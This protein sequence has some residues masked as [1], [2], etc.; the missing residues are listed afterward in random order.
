MTLATDLLSKITESMT[1]KFEDAYVTVN[2]KTK[3]RVGHGR[4][5]STEAR[6]L[7]YLEGQN[8]HK[9]RN[10]KVIQVSDALQQGYEGIDNRLGIV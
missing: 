10:I 9:D 1:T 5:Y 2:I 8:W 4:L 3:K 7:D 6:A